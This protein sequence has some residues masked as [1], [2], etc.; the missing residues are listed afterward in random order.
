MYFYAWITRYAKSSKMSSEPNNAIYTTDDAKTVK[1][2][3]NKYA[4]LV[5]K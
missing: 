3:I 4:F 1:N 2:K 5:G